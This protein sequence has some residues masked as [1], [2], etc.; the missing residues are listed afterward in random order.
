[1][2]VRSKPEQFYMFEWY[3]GPRIMTVIHGYPMYYSTGRN[4]KFANTWLP[5]LGLDGN[6]WLRKPKICLPKEIIKFC[7]KIKLDKKFSLFR[8]GN[9]ETLCI[10]A[11]LGKGIWYYLEGILLQQF[12]ESK[13]SQYFLTNEETYAILKCQKEGTHILVSDV[14]I[15][16]AHLKQLGTLIPVDFYSRLPIEKECD[17]FFSSN[18]T[19][20]QT[21]LCMMLVT[22]KNITASAFKMLNKFSKREELFDYGL[23]YGLFEIYKN[24]KKLT[25]LILIKRKITLIDLIRMN[26]LN[27]IVLPLEYAD[28][29][30]KYSYR[31]ILRKLPRFSFTERDCALMKK[32]DDLNLLDRYSATF[33]DKS[34]REE[35]YTLFINKR[36]SRRTVK[37]VQEKRLSQNSN[38]VNATS[39]ANLL[40]QHG[41]FANANQPVAFEVQEKHLTNGRPNTF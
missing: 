32:L 41:L 18:D 19:K 35:L 14:A 29:P 23:S 3:G 34:S 5:F 21:A 26:P 2:Q 1:M 40:N 7:K 30:R 6:C 28:F 25:S 39:D 24:I 36:I 33:I 11:S 9:I 16:N 37:E 38:Q 27:G 22:H 20:I 15:A 13:Y 31:K 17:F 8:F 10:S 12:L 4:S